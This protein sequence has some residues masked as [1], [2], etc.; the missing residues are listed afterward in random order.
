MTEAATDAYIRYAPSVGT[1]VMAY[2]FHIEAATDLVVVRQR[3]DVETTLTY[4]TDYAVSGVGVAGGGNVTLVV[5]SLASDIYA[6]YRNEANS[7][8]T[9]YANPADIRTENMNNEGDKETR[10]IQQLARD[11]GRSLRVSPTDNINSN[12]LTDPV[13]LPLFT[14]S[15]NSFLGRT[16]T[17]EFFWGTAVSGDVAVSNFWASILAL[18]TI[19]LARSGL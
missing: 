8:A 6:I 19:E 3:D 7:R 13:L 1:T 4:S 16:T 9:S 5:A 11:L 14:E 12:P 2:D 15:V 17:G 10:L 18:S